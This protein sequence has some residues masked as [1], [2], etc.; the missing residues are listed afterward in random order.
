M[1]AAD[2]HRD[3]AVLHGEVAGQ[4]G[5]RSACESPAP[6]APLAQALRAEGGVVTVSGL[7]NGSSPNPGE[8]IATRDSPPPR[9][10]PGDIVES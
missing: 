9:R 2:D 7:D 4:R 1:A 3:V 5:R 6:C 8:D 10:F